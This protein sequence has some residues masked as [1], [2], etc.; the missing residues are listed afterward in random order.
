MSWSHGVF[1]WNELMTWDVERA[2]RFYAL[3]IGWTFED[4]PMPDGKYWVARMGER[5]VGGL[6]QLRKPEFVGVG[7]AWMPYLAVDDVD[8]RAARATAAGAELMRPLFDVPMVGRIAMLRQPGGAGI[9][10]IT[11]ADQD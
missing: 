5:Y 9:G 3:T 1:H 7:E 8:A 6:F 11:P 10:W 2:R 4:H